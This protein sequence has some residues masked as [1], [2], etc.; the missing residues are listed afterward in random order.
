[1]GGADSSHCFPCP[2]LA[3]QGSEL[4]TPAAFAGSARWNI[5]PIDV[6]GGPSRHDEQRFGL[7]L[8]EAV[9]TLEREGIPYAVFGSVAEVIYGRPAEVEDI[10]LLIAPPDADDALEALG[11]AG[12]DT[13]KT[14]QTWLYKATKDGVVVDL[15]FRIAGDIHLD[16]EVLAHTRSGEFQ[17]RSIRLVAPEDAVVI[18]AAS[19]DA[20][21][22]QHWFNALAIL[23]AQR[24]D[25]PYLAARARYALRRVLSLLVYAQSTD[26]AVPDWVIRSLVE[27]AY[28][29]PQ[30]GS[31]G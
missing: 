23:A 7:V 14:E 10:D 28:P 17:G 4:R 2:D 9:D 29:S 18:E 1:M 31:L 13:E 24:L 11:R 22:P 19:T 26:L 8:A 16:Q 25:W 21:M 20:R 15:I 27:Q 12:F 30:T 3:K 6:K 5:R